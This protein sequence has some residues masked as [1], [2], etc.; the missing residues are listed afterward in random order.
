MKQYRCWWADHKN[1]F[2]GSMK[3]ILTAFKDLNPDEE[4]WFMWEYV[5]GADGWGDY[6]TG[7]GLTLNE[8]ER[9][10][11]LHDKA[12]CCNMTIKRVL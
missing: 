9:D 2:F 7:G 6:V 5:G 4:E 8:F 10:S 1:E 12:E 3:D 11:N